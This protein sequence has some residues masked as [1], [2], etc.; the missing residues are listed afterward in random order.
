MAPGKSPGKSPAK[1]RAADG[2][3]VRVA[4]RVRP[5]NE[6]E[7]GLGEACCVRMLEGETL[8]WNKETG[9]EKSFQFDHNLWS[10]S[11]ADPHFASQE[12]VFGEVGAAALES[13]FE[14]FNSTIF[15]YGQTGS[16]K[17]FTMVGHGAEKG[18]VP[19]IC[20][21]VFE[22]VA[23]LR[24]EGTE[25]SVQM[26]MLE[27]YS[28]RVSDLLD[29]SP[30]RASLKTRTHPSGGAYV[31]GLQNF[32]VGTA[33]EAAKILEIGNKARTIA[34][35]NM[36]ST[37]SRAHT[38]FTLTLSLRD[39]GGVETTSKLNLVDLAGSER[40]RHTK[41]TGKLLKEGAAINKSLSSLGNCINALVERAKGNR[42]VHVPYRDS[43]L[44]QLLKDS[45]GGN[46][47]TVMIASISPSAYHYEETLSTLRYAS[48]AKNI[49]NKPE[50][51]VDP[52]QRQIAAL[53]VEIARLKEDLE[54]ERSGKADTPQKV[55][56]TMQEQLHLSEQLHGEL[57]KPWEEKRSDTAS[58]LGRME[59][60]FSRMGLHE[61][62]DLAVPAGPYLLNLNE[63]PSMSAK[64]V[65][66]LRADVTQVGRPA[67]PSFEESGIAL[68]GPSIKLEHAHFEVREGEVFLEAD[69]EGATF[70]NGERLAPGGRRQVTSGDRVVFG[71]NHYFT[72]HDPASE[73]GAGGGA[74]GDEVEAERMDWAF[75]QRELAEK[76]IESLMEEHRHELEELHEQ[77]KEKE[78]VLEQQLQEREA[79]FEVQRQ[80]TSE[81]L[82]ALEKGK[83]ELNQK[84]RNSK[85]KINSLALREKALETKLDTV[86]QEHDDEKENASKV[87]EENARMSKHL[88]RQV[89]DVE[90]FKR[91]L[92]FLEKTTKE[93]L[94]QRYADLGEASKDIREHRKAV[95]DY[96]LTVRR[97]L[98]EE[99]E[100][101]AREQAVVL[102]EKEAA[103]AAIDAVKGELR[104]K[105]R[106]VEID[107]DEVA[108]KD[109]M[110][111]LMYFVSNATHMVDDAGR[112][113][114][115]AMEPL[116][117]FPEPN[118][119][120][121][122]VEACGRCEGYQD[123]AVL[124][125]TKGEVEVY[126][127]GF[128]EFVDWYDH[129]QDFLNRAQEPD[130]DG[131]LQGPGTDIFYS[132]A[133][134]PRLLGV[135]YLYL[136]PAA[137]LLPTSGAPAVYGPDGEV[138]GSLRVSLDV[139]LEVGGAE[140]PEPDALA[141]ALGQAAEVRL[142]FSG[143]EGWDWE[144]HPEFFFRF[145]LG[146]EEAASPTFHTASDVAFVHRHIINSV[147]AELVDLVTAGAF[148]VEVLTWTPEA[149]RAVEEEIGAHRAEKQ[150]LL[151]VLSPRK[152]EAEGVG[153]A[154]AEEPGIAGTAA[155]GAD[156]GAA[157]VEP[158]GPAAAEVEATPQP[159]KA[160]SF[161][162]TPVPALD[163]GGASP[164]SAVVPDAPAW[165][166]AAGKAKAVT[167]IAGGGGKEIKSVPVVDNRRS[168]LGCGASRPGEA[169][170]SCAV[171]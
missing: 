100:K 83:E 160:V 165:V 113:F 52:T 92:E 23:A 143:V 15:A 75:A 142:T 114:D 89:D 86:Q 7:R 14:G 133:L 54:R 167:A 95:E 130:D 112:S 149:Q 121:D 116:T 25:C 123:A 109:R 144:A 118:L 102:R 62:A 122:G 58:H 129:L 124:L 148:R 77:H 80:E 145:R 39:R 150:E 3:A 134:Q 32:A 18:I 41:A 70:V 16:G 1:A 170:G 44:T 138:I 68:E 139:S 74:S 59:R 24:A 85:L 72:F 128:E 127:F 161:L 12:R 162:D 107:R 31:E 71:G 108:L 4:V 135:A 46:A 79:E 45:L 28:E 82:A 153:P 42:K 99:K 120:A 35:T 55:L 64:L 155:D 98:V 78:G 66:A 67:S 17:S 49:Q 103:E 19:R 69:G 157:E 151:D 2:A 29:L 147:S 169:N 171:M 22:R 40:S 93:F 168:G 60:A 43:I 156:A 11:A 6:R 164:V 125:S 152:A 126:R 73:E 137:Y 61:P 119:E 84:L 13:A 37:S 30:G 136:E 106:A 48:R 166:K 110:L 65:Y 158:G 10:F 36:N 132:L 57:Q 117:R 56:D 8:L 97:E 76:Q 140:G 131:A 115:F 141:D 5:F 146:N 26:S 63:D 53:Q 51:N 163:R 21:G 81:K 111:Q 27:I 91:E 154:T 38:I 20:H 104:Q 96:L 90:S 105:E 87:Q 33:R 50:V 94:E 159:N 88:E 9:K 34:S 47:R 101:L